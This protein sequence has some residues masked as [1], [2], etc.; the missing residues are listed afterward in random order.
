MLITALDTLVGAVITA[1]AAGHG[2]GGALSICY[3]VALVTH[4]QVGFWLTVVAMTAV[5]TYHVL[6]LSGVCGWIAQQRMAWTLRHAAS[7][8]RRRYSTHRP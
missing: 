3:D 5:V 2:G 7:R 8:P 4:A 1:D 6:R